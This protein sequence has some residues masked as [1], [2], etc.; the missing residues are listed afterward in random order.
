MTHYILNFFYSIKDVFI[1]KSNNENENPNKRP[2]FNSEE[3][4]IEYLR[5]NIQQKKAKWDI[6]L[7]MSETDKTTHLQKRSSKLQKKISNTM[8]ITYDLTIDD[9]NDKR[10]SENPIP[11]ENTYDLTIDDSNDIEDITP[12]RD[13][14]RKPLSSVPLHHFGKVSSTPLEQNEGFFNRFKNNDRVTQLRPSKSKFLSPKLSVS[15]NKTTASALNETIRLDEKRK[16]SEMLQSYNIYKSQKAIN[17]ETQIKQ[18]EFRHR[19]DN[20]PIIQLIDLSKEEDTYIPVQHVNMLPLRQNKFENVSQKLHKHVERVNSF[21]E[22][23]KSC[24]A[25]RPE[26][27]SNMVKKYE[28][29]AREKR[30]EVKEAFLKRQIYGKY[31]QDFANALS[32]RIQKRLSITEV[33]LDEVEEEPYL[34]ELTEEMKK[35]VEESWIPSPPGQIIVENFGQRITRSDITTLSGLHWLNDEVI[36]FYMNLL[37][38]RGKSKN[39]PNI[40]AFN[41]FFYQKLSSAGHSSLKRWTKKVDIFSQD[42]I[43]V[44]IHLGMHWCLAVIFFKDKCIKYYD[45]MG[46]NNN[47]CLKLL[48]KYLEDESLDKKKL[49]YDTSDWKLENVKD[50]PQQMNGS[51]CG[52]FSCMF[53]E[54]ISRNCKITF[55]QKEM[56]YFR[57][58]MAYEIITGKLLT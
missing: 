14:I 17:R 9:A 32:E 50:I 10:R 35:K 11:Y 3:D 16:F 21:E 47:K 46:G 54:F 18:L 28:E 37:I 8:G 12:I 22:K 25:I 56:P 19:S 26:W 13:S 27:I 29:P 51:D 39:L 45:S 33:I 30:R 23:I 57:I 43:L 49:P 38:E 2:R 6:E 15:K 40:Y 24:N 34:P 48:L 20:M 44:P 53:A 36:N 4:D 31:N 58:K 5:P 55:T 41:T 52:M 1:S 7:A 42:M